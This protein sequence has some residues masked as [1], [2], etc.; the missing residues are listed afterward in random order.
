IRSHYVALAA[1][2]LGWHHTDGDLLAPAFQMLGLELFTT[3]SNMKLHHLGEKIRSTELNRK[4]QDTVLTW[5]TV[6]HFRCI[7]SMFVKNEKALLKSPFSLAAH[8]DWSKSH[9]PV[10][11]HRVTSVLSEVML[12]YFICM[13]LA[14]DQV[15][16][17]S[18]TT[19]PQFTAEIRVHTSH[20]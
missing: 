17:S 5:L 1:L 10:T 7:P 15:L 12:S 4:H 9:G 19:P 16:C 2:G 6:W 11:L 14:L 8:G 3:I 20:S 18:P 13:F